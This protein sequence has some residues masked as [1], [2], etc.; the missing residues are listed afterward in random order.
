[1][2]EKNLL[3]GEIRKDLI[4]VFYLQEKRVRVYDDFDVKFKEFLLDAPDFNPTKLE[5]ICKETGNEMNCI[6][7]EIIQIKLNFSP[8]VYNVPFL[9]NLVERLQDL[10]QLK[11]KTVS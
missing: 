6:S 3:T 8:Q 10:E 11:F 9:F 2:D 4:Q 1:M 7:R 5:L